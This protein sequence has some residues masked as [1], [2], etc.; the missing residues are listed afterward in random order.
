MKRPHLGGYS[1]QGPA[2]PEGYLFFEYTWLGFLPHLLLFVGAAYAVTRKFPLATMVCVLSF[3]CWHATIA[4]QTRYQGGSI[5]YSFAAVL[6]V[7]GLGPAWDVVR[8]SRRTAGRVL[9]ACFSMVFV[10]HALLAYNLLQ[11]GGL[12]NLQFLW[13]GEPAPDRH[14]V[15]ARVV[16][17]IRAAREICIPFTRWEVLYWNF[18]RF[19]PSA[20]YRARISSCRH[21]GR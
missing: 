9:M 7:A 13:R 12:R 11:F 10:T 20:R 19:N 18:M 21:R 17:A 8:S 15:D 6:A 4:M 3:F 2:N 5:Y 1:F 14:P 16:E